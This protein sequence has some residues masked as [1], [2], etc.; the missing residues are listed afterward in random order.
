MTEKEKKQVT[1]IYFTPEQTA[2]LEKAM[3]KMVKKETGK[4]G[5]IRKGIKKV[6]NAFFGFFTTVLT[7]KDTGK[8]LSTLSVT[9]G[10]YLFAKFLY[11]NA[12]SVAA[13]TIVAPYIGQ[14]VVVV[15]GVV[16]GF[17]GAQ[18]IIERVKE[19][20]DLVET[21]ASTIKGKKDE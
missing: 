10:M 9:I 15:F 2:M 16:G 18:S 12:Y 11:V 8:W 19:N 6:I 13:M 21:V 17:K 7:L 5:I 3:E 14:I 1:E 4:E 20:K